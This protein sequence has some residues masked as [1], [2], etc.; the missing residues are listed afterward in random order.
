M[1]SMT[2]EEQWRTLEGEIGDG[3]W[4]MLLARPQ[5]GYALFTAI[6]AGSKRRSLLLRVP[7]TLVPARRD[8]PACRGLEPVALR[9][10]GHPHFGVVL[11]DARYTD[12]F[13]AL[14]EDLARRI[15]DAGSAQNAVRTLVGQLARWQNFL[16]VPVE[17]L[18]EGAQRGL[19]GELCFL[20]ERLIPT[21][22]A[23]AIMA[24]KGP[25]K[26][27]QD[28]QLPRVAVEIKTT[29]AKQP[30]MVSISS[31][32]QLDDAHWSSLF[33]HVFIL[34]VHQGGQHTLPAAV[35]S[36]RQAFAFHEVERERFE[37]ALLAAGYLDVHAHRYADRSYAIREAS[38]FRVKD[39]FPRITEA[40]LPDGI[41]SVSYGLNLASCSPFLVNVTEMLAA[42]TAPGPL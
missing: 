14:A 41:G 8:W 23:G 6:E 13:S 25:E 40:G 33:L 9:L 35:E 42:L 32:R 26:G 3:T 30:Q 20:S 12:V 7:E 29:I 38:T 10:D 31:E 27:H 19:W 18:G 36:I 34:E 37:V 5:K 11:G 4:R 22:G 24:W 1:P 28:F 2:I 39:G 17:G 21:L 15:T 16:A